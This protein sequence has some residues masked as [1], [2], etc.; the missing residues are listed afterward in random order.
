MREDSFEIAKYFILDKKISPNKLDGKG[1]SPIFFSCASGH[2]R[3]VRFLI[4]NGADV[5]H[6]DRSG[7]APIHVAT[8][9][10]HFE[11]FRFWWGSA[12]IHLTRSD[13]KTAYDCAI[14]L[15]HFQSV[16]YFC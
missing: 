6:Q 9:H 12:D 4:E 16:K 15:G 7:Q 2:V 10:D 14:M 5:D 3:I 8:L 13:N 11:T 1:K